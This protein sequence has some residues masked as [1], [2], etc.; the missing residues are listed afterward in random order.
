MVRR[1][2]LHESPSES[3]DDLPMLRTI[4]SLAVPV[5]LSLLVTACGGYFLASSKAGFEAT[6]KQRAA[7]DLGCPI[8][9][10]Q[11]TEIAS[12]VTPATPDEAGKGGDGTVIG[13]SG[14]G[15]RA[16]YKYVQSAGWVAQTTASQ[17]LGHR[18]TSNGSVP[19][20]R[21]GRRRSAAI[22][23]ADLA[24]LRLLRVR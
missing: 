8:D 23:I 20:R 21:G 4:A 2:D 22:S 17:W 10:V 7:F 24:K 15:R 18:L 3:D 12:G 14:C 19:A 13:V 11:V 6:E 5:S 16:T 1:R 9:Q